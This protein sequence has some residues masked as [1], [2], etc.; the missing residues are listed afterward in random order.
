MEIYG[1]LTTVADEY[2]SSS[3]I[4][5]TNSIQ[6]VGQDRT[7][8]AIYNMY[9]FNLSSDFGIRCYTDWVLGNPIPNQ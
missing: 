8:Y 3:Y 4:N 1:S 2:L 6:Q 5:I 9:Y 7:Q